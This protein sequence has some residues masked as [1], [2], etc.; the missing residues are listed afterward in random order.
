M[1][2]KFQTYSDTVY[3]SVVTDLLLLDPKRLRNS[4]LISQVKTHFDTFLGKALLIRCNE[5]MKILPYLP[6]V[7]KSSKVLVVYPGAFPFQLANDFGLNGTSK[8]LFCKNDYLS[9]NL[10]RSELLN[11]HEKAKYIKCAKDFDQDLPNLVF[12]SIETLFDAAYGTLHNHKLLFD[13]FDTILVCNAEPLLIR[14]QYCDCASPWYRIHQVFSY[15]WKEKLVFFTNLIDQ[16]DEKAYFEP[17]MQELFED[18]TPFPK[19]MTSLEIE[20]ENL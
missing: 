3:K 14:G 15:T 8:S 16:T 1:C 17:Y 12:T 20:F 19:N 4:S 18:S 13:Y 7:L 9:N 6:Y 2:S 5:Q 11:F 10:K